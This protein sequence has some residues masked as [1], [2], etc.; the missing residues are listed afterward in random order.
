[1]TKPATP[2]LL[3]TG[4]AGFIGAAFVADCNR[5]G[6]PVISI[7]RASYFESRTEHAGTD[8]GQIVDRDELFDW[9]ER[10]QPALAGVVHLGACSNTMETDEEYLR[11]VNVEYSQKLWRYC[12]ERK[13]TFVYASSAA[14]Y[15]DG[16]DGYADDESRVGALQPL[17]LYGR[18]KQLFDLWVLEQERAGTQPPAWSGF[19]FFNVYGPGERH[20][21]KMASVV[22]HAYDQIQSKGGMQLFKSHKAGIADGEQKRDFI[23]VVD[24]V[25]V[26]RFALEKPIRRGIYNLGTGEAR[27][28][29]DLARAVFK[30]MGRAEKI[31]FVPTP[32]AIRDKYQ[33]FTQA[34]MERLRVQGYTAQFLSLESG[35]A[36]Y[37]QKLKR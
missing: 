15:G 7:D 20:K 11:R 34:T 16:A 27:S 28:F 18:S 4:A 29:L 33:Y 25:A 23:S 36:D 9:L 22:L 24:V 1:M 3:V 2:P 31:D 13:L 8:F 35:V 5:R 37:L 19:K 12:Q 32:E 17:N 30:A 26:L 6:V 10:E 14:T 21:G